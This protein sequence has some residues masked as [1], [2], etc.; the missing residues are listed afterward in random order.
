M[1]K[2]ILLLLLILFTLTTQAQS[3]ELDY[4]SFQQMR[5]AKWTSK[6]LPDMT[7]H[8]D[9]RDLNFEPKVVYV[10]HG[11]KLVY[12]MKATK[13]F[14]VLRDMNE[15]IKVLFKPTTFVLANGA[16]YRRRI[17]NSGKLLEVYDRREQLI[18]RAHI[19]KRK[20][21]KK[22]LKVEIIKPTEDNQALLTLMAIDLLEYYRI[23]YNPIF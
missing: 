9:K 6:I 3:Y 19:I 17:S 13:I 18:A 4:D 20:K 22:T 23:E 2:N 10:Y 14:R 21:P 7:I 11:D 1:K 16:R 15:E 5:V 8:Y 12:T